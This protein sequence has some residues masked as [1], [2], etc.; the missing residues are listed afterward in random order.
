MAASGHHNR[1]PK[2]KPDVNKLAA[3][4]LQRHFSDPTGDQ[5][6]N[7]LTSSSSN[8]VTSDLLL[9]SS[10][11]PGCRGVGGSGEGGV[12]QERIVQEEEEEEDGLERLDARK[13]EDEEEAWGHKG[14]KD[15]GSGGLGRGALN[16]N[17]VDKGWSG[18]LS[19]DVE[20]ESSEDINFKPSSQV[21]HNSN[22][23]ICLFYLFYFTKRIGQGNSI[24]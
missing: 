2:H 12:L 9:S 10:S 22:H 1:R 8:L 13:R 4:N 24:I 15:W 20:D 18:T 16:K 7:N 21:Y 11:D 6:S 3:A 14:G 19:V 23:K 17:L 5:S